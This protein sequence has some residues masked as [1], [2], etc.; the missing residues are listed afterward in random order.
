MKTTLTTLALIASVCPAIAA[1]LTAE[2]KTQTIDSLFASM[3]KSYVFPDKAKEAEDAIRARLQRGEYAEVGDGQAFAKLLTE[4]LREVC[5]DAHLRVRY[6]EQTLPARKQNDKPSAEEIAGMR[7]WESAMNAA[8]EKV[9]RLA[10]NVGYIKFNGFTSPA[11]AERPIRAAMDFV[12]DTDALIFDIRDNGGGEP[13]T[14]RLLCSYL[15]GE[16]PVHLNDIYDRPTNKTEEFWTL[17][18]VAGRRYLNKDVYVLTSK[19]SASGAEEFAYNLKNLKRATIVGESTWG[20]AN[21]GEM[22]RL[23]DH[24]GAFVPTGR[25]I[26]PITKTNWEGTGVEPDIKVPASDALKASHL[27]AIKR[28]IERT[29]DAEHK[30]RLERGLKELEE[31]YSK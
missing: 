18:K 27:L 29:T 28:L 13:A 3:N 4:H 20:G 5:K 31:R 8:F 21:P 6:S 22:V 16:K 26:N 25:A 11:G 30:G 17:K 2:T 9:E 1:E 12:A 19:R 7:R 14:V 15:F 24:F 10:G 23:N